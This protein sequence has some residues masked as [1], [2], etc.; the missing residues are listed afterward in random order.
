MILLHVTFPCI[1]VFF[2]TESGDSYNGSWRQSSKMALLGCMPALVPDTQS[3]SLT[4]P[5]T[6]RKGAA[7]SA[8]YGN[9]L[10]SAFMTKNH[11]SWD[12][13]LGRFGF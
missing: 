2:H 11:R 9:I 5:R 6:Q 3:K 12:T 8:S 10:L 13:L 1:T 7:Q 4:V